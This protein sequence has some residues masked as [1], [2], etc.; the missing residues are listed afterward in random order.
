MSQGIHKLAP[1]ALSDGLSRL[2]KLLTLLCVSY[3]VVFGFVYSIDPMAKSPQLDAHENLVIAKEIDSGI[4]AKEPFYRA[5]V[6]PFFLSLLEPT[7]LR[8][9]IGLWIG[10]A[11]H[12]VSGWL[13]FLVAGR[14][15]QSPWGRRIPAWLYLINPASVFYAAQLLD[16]TMATTFFLGGLW[17][18]VR[19]T[20]RWW[21]VLSFGFLLGLAALARPHF[22]PIALV[23][24]A[25]I[26]FIKKDVSLN[27]LLA[28]IPLFGLLLV[29]GMINQF[30]NGDFRILPWQ[31]AYNLWAA[32]KPGA[33]GLYFK[34]VVDLSQRDDA[35]NPARVES[36]H[37]YGQAH[38]DEQPPYS[39]DAMNAN[40]RSEFIN[41]L[42]EN[43]LEVAKMWLLKAYAVVNAFEQYNNLTFSFH[44]ERLPLLRYNPLNW[45]ILL[46]LGTLGLMQL[47][48]TDSRKAVA[49][50]M[51]IL[52]YASMLLLF[53]AS[54]RFR[55]PMVPLM[56]VLAGGC[57]GWCTGLLKDRRRLAITLV[58]VTLVGGITFSSF[59]DIR[60]TDTYIQ[61][62][63]LMANANADLGHDMEAARWA[64]EVLEE[65]PSRGEALRIYAVSYFNLAI[66]GQDPERPFG[67]W[68]EQR[69]WVRQSPPT[70][71]VQD[72][73][74]GVF[75]WKW[76]EREQA[77]ELWQK[78]ATSGT[79]GD[80]L[81]QAALKAT[82]QPHT[83]LESNPLAYA[84]ADLLI[85]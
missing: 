57:S 79:P 82:D 53:Y 1:K 52:A 47:W 84:L 17:M 7:N 39:I 25:A 8:P 69:E 80:S 43:P 26:L 64:R 16:V 62:R 48:W 29:Q 41:H 50:M 5:M 81:A 63:L 31:G 4:V 20:Q 15:W 78:I 67:N 42:I 23:S 70:D 56:A 38:P 83:S 34:Q 85:N 2:S 27:P 44:K 9:Q 61:D 68:K 35:T 77:Q 54:A 40:W 14:I 3:V 32:N 46:I 24:P 11:C 65:N 28:T 55:L 58:A 30:Q 59:A 6:Y 33:N 37:L 21:T 51:I 18:G 74:L 66:T 45:G 12:L 36:V 10:I 19:P 49:W 13:V 72:A 71:P 73:V 60:S 22:L 76:G 75:M